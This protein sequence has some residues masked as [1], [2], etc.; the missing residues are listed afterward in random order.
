MN[1]DGIKTIQHVGIKTIESIDGSLEHKRL[2][3]F[4]VELPQR[5]P[6]ES[7]GGKHEGDNDPVNVR[8]LLRLTGMTLNSPLSP[9]AAGEMV[10]HRDPQ[11]HTL[12]LG[13]TTDQRSLASLRAQLSL[14]HGKDS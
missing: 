1:H 12:R 2:G 5:D 11:Q 8:L 13:F 10:F 7:E 4:N 14:K 3:S 9:L 6:G